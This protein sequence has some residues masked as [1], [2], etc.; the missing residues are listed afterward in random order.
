MGGGVYVRVVGE[1]FAGGIAGYVLELRCG[2]V[3][4]AVFMVAGVP[5][6]SRRLHA[7]SERVAAFDELDAAGSTVVDSWGDEDVD[8]VGMIAKP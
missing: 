7:G 2:D 8:V 5:Y 4:D 1:K 3:A 6:L